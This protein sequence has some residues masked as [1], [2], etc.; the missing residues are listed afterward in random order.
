VEKISRNQSNISMSCALKEKEMEKL[1]QKSSSYEMK[2]DED[3]NK[4]IS[5]DVDRLILR[6]A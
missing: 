4:I 5:S 1:K 6:E 3:L 2:R